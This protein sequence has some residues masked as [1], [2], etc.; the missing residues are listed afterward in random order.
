VH[1]DQ[2][3]VARNILHGLRQTGSVQGLFSE[4]QELAV[5]IPDM[6]MPEALDKVRPGLK[7][8]LF[9]RF[10]IHQ[11]RGNNGLR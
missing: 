10:E 9:G 6:S 4:F 5:L 7:G 8:T 1:L 11:P 3:W 2:K